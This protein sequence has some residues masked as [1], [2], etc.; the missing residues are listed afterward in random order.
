MYGLGMDTGDERFGFA[1]VLSRKI[2]A[3]KMI[4][5]DERTSMDG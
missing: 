3:G 5:M 2:N 1:F 4:E